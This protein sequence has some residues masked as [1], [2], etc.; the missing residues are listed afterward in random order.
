MKEIET[1]V[2]VYD[3]VFFWMSC[4][5]LQHATSFQ[6]LLNQVNVEI[7]APGRQVLIKVSRLEQLDPHSVAAVQAFASNLG[8]VNAAR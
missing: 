7:T 2:T 4:N 1:T 6:M 5:N 8:H 3:F